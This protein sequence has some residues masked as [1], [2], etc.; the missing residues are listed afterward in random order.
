MKYRQDENG[1]II[2][3]F[4]VVINFKYG[5]FIGYVYMQ[6]IYM[7]IY[8][9][10]QSGYIPAIKQLFIRSH[11][12]GDD[13]TNDQNS[14]ATSIGIWFTDCLFFLDFGSSVRIQSL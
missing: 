1:S 10:K 3:K 12:I 4:R 13:Q 2:F 14:I 9:Y 5:I 11:K 6:Y 8:I 7:Y